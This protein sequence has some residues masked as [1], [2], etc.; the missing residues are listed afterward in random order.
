M[1]ITLR[2][3]ER[4][5]GINELELKHMRTGDYERYKSLYYQYIKPKYGKQLVITGNT[6]GKL[7]TFDDFILDCTARQPQLIIIDFLT[8][9]KAI[10]QSDLDF[11]EMAMPQILKYAHMYQASFL[12]LSQMS[13]SSRTDQAGGQIGGHGKGGGKIEELAAT[14]IELLRH[15][16]D[17]EETKIIAAIT[18]ARR[19]KAYKFFNLMYIGDTKTFTGESELWVRD[20]GRSKSAFRKVG[21]YA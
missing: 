12:I 21:F 15:E 16:E 14:E 8:N 20:K 9:L 7:L 10:G 13:R 1:D 19:G 2:L 4:E 17:G 6:G 5:S 18:K 3:L 11:V